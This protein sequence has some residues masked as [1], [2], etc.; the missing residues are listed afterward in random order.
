MKHRVEA[1]YPASP[2]VVMK[3]FADQAFHTRKLDA[4]GFE[5]RVLACRQDEKSFQIR[6]ERKIPLDLP[7]LKSANTTVVNDETWNLAA[8]TGAVTV[9]L[10]APLTASCSV[11]LKADGDATLIRYDW[12]VNSKVPLIGGKIEK[13]AVAD[14]DKRSADEAR[15]AIALLK[16]YR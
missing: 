1:R 12:D 16:H 13:M 2:D 11:T 14:M 15:A 10:A 3:M 7:G 6:I 4:L 5:Y 8:K 9:E